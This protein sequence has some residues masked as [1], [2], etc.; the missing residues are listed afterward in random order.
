MLQQTVSILL[1]F[2]ASRDIVF[3]QNMPQQKIGM[4]KKVGMIDRIDN[5]PTERKSLTQDRLFLA[6]R[7]HVKISNASAFREIKR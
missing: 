2:Y 7:N 3:Q 6:D 1:I 5:S 4:S